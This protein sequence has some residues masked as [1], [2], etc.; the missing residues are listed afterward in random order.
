[1]KTRK[2]IDVSLL[3]ELLR[4]YNE[5]G[6]DNETFEDFILNTS[7]TPDDDDNWFYVWNEVDEID[8]RRVAKD[9]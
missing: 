5:E 6:Y 9:D 1:M 2:M 8:I 3:N 7:D 4:D